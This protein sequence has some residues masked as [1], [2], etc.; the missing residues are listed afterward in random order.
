MGRPINEAQGVIKGLIPAVRNQPCPV[1]ARD[2]PTNEPTDR[3][4][5]ALLTHEIRLAAGHEPT[6]RSWI[7]DQVAVFVV[8]VSHPLVGWC[9]QIILQQPFGG[10]PVSNRPQHGKSRTE[11]EP[12]PELPAL[13]LCGKTCS[14]AF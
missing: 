5:F 9:L 1:P 14:N 13:Y 12:V 6:S 4:D 10:Q 8:H 3:W 2:E 11:L 7:H